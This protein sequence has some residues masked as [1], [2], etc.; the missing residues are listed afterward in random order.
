ML[1]GSWLATFTGR[2]AANI[3]TEIAG[4][5]SGGSPLAGILPGSVSA[6]SGPTAGVVTWA[7]PLSAADAGTIT[8]ALGWDATGPTAAVGI[9]DFKL[10]DGALGIIGG[11]W[12]RGRIDH[13]R[14]SFGV[15]LQQA[16][17]IAV[18][19][20]LS[21]TES[22]GTFQLELYPL[23]SG[24][25][26]KRSPLARSPRLHAF[27]RHTCADGLCA[28][29]REMARPAGGQHAARH[30]MHQEHVHD[31]P[32]VRRAPPSGCSHRLGDCGSERRGAW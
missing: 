3:A 7:L 20:T 26:R 12:I 18:T 13:R 23:A 17:G 2:S 16:I 30:Q 11:R 4:V 5:F 22:G 9:A 14:R 10:G 29:H 25:R 32:V 6:G 28:A 27:S 24:S 21:F 31:A 8:V 19:P 15:H 1:N